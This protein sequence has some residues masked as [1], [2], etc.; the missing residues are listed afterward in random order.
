MNAT[1]HA[2]AEYRSR[3]GNKRY[4][5]EI[6]DSTSQVVSITNFNITPEGAVITYE[7][8]EQDV[9]ANI[10]SS[11][12]N[13]SLICE[14][15]AQLDFLK[16]IV[17]SAIGRFGVRLLIANNN[18]TPVLTKWV[19]T[20][21]SDQITFSDSI[22]QQVS[23]TATDDLGY[24]KDIPYLDE[25]GNRFRGNQS[26]KEHIV[27]ALSN[28][29]TN[30][31]YGYSIDIGGVPF[32]TLLFGYDVD[33]V[34]DSYVSANSVTKKLIDEAEISNLIFYKDDE[35]EDVLN[36]HEVLTRI[37]KYLNCSFY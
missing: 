14:T 37:F 34:P 27:Q 30:W 4:T 5:L 35:D 12:L 8:T 32:F 29:R 1:I 36:C 22:P 3:F 15:Q 16:G 17:S 6:V 28:L 23:F 11:T 26:I 20:L 10:I 13:F 7:S 24:L 25:N 9:F 2:R 33:L 18:S 19:G 31:Y 21:I